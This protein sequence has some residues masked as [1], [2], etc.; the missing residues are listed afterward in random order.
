[1]APS[2]HASGW[3]IINWACENYFIHQLLWGGKY[4]CIF[5]KR[6]F[7]CGWYKRCPRGLEV[8][9]RKRTSAPIVTK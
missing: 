5:Y 3:P 1:M 9:E 8:D 4:T 6:F 2:L 7:S